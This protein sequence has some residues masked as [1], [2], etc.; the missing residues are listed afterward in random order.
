MPSGP[1]RPAMWI[2]PGSISAQTLNTCPSWPA[3]G[4]RTPQSPGYV[5]GKSG[6][7]LASISS[8]KRSTCGRIVL[9]RRA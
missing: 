7:G 4:T 8:T 2:S 9:R 1:A 3:I 5:T 6:S